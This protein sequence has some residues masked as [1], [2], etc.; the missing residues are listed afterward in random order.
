MEIR[1]DVAHLTERFFH[2]VRL[3]GDDLDGQTRR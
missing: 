1:L 3:R 2:L